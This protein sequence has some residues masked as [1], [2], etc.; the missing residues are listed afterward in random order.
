MKTE[1]KLAGTLDSLAVSQV[2]VFPLEL[3]DNTDSIKGTASV[4]LNDQLL[5]NGLRIV[6]GTNGFFVEFPSDS[7]CNGEKKGMLVSP[8]TDALRDNIE[9][10]VLEKYKLVSRK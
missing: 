7:F 1:K 6:E 2:Q 10:C 9:K 3:G 5:I 8:F 4:V